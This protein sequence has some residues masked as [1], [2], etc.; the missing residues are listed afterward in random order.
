VSF[1]YYTTKT[2]IFNLVQGENGVYLSNKTQIGTGG[3]PRADFEEW[4]K[5]GKTSVS[6]SKSSF[7]LE[8]WGKGGW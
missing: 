3:M 5:N 8:K 7:F 4:P 1:S 6:P 2:E